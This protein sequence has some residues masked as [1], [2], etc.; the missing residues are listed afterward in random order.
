MKNYQNTLYFFLLLFIVSCTI[1]KNYNVKYNNTNLGKYLAASYSVQ[2]GDSAFASS[3]LTDNID[4]SK[5]T[6]LAELAF[7]S[8]II[9]GEFEA[10]KKLKKNYPNLLDKSS[11]SLIP[12]IVINL[13]NQNYEEAIKLINISSDLPGFKS[14][15]Q[16]IK[17]IINVSS[18]LKKQD[19]IDIFSKINNPDIYDLLIFED[20]FEISDSVIIDKLNKKYQSEINNFLISGYL[21][22]KKLLEK[23][24]YFMNNL[25]RDFDKKKIIQNFNSEEN[26][27]KKKPSFSLLI[28]SY[29][30]EIAI[31]NSQ[32]KNIPSSYLKMLLEMS[33]F[34]YP[35]L[36]FPN[37]YLAKIFAQENNADLA[38]KKLE[39][40]SKNSFVYLPS[41][42]NKYKII[43]N[44]DQTN[45]KNILDI[46][47][48]RYSQNISVQYELADYYRKTEQCSKAIDIFN[49]ILK[50]E[51]DNYR[52]QFFKASCLEKLDLWEESKK[53][54]NDIITK[55]KDPYALN[56]L[57]YSMTIRNE[58]LNL[59]LQL[60]NEA[61]KKEPNN[62]YFLDTLGW[63]QFKKKEY[64]LAVKNLQR[65]VSIQPN[66]SEI[67]DHLGDCYYKM[68]RKKEA[69]F[70][71]NRALIFD[72]DENLKQ[73]IEK[74]IKLYET[75]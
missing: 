35:E 28:S 33:N 32:N 60:I 46:M 73:K 71:W 17:N 36:E 54:F 58:N 67:M 19:L 70:E 10:A 39:I 2:N 49:E 11:F 74:K 23:N 20:A 62:G 44:L 56:Y 38:V 13:K 31:R 61:L 4:Y 18:N 47:I 51:K 22:R 68:G 15:E 25:H 53:V 43:K 50:I 7:F 30:T 45:S 5:D 6:K 63:V 52:F 40:I 26:I 12:E 37:Y 21:Y 55:N 34:I 1:N 72:A 66:S 8:K 75:N 65:A 42:L 16:K 69:F 14:F 29:L 41:L 3:I 24:N 48:K 27:F 59:A 57:S 64:K 9:N